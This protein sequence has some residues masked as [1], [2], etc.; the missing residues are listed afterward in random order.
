MKIDIPAWYNNRSDKE[1]TSIISAVTGILSTIFSIATNKLF[2]I[3][4]N[5]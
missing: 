5:K 1:K 2:N 3:S 4:G